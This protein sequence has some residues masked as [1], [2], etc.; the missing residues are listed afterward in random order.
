[1]R[2]KSPSGQVSL[3]NAASH[4]RPSMAL[5]LR[6]SR[7][8]GRRTRRRTTAPAAAL[9]GQPRQAR[10]CPKARS[11]LRIGQSSLAHAR[12]PAG[13]A[14]TTVADR[15]GVGGVGKDFHWVMTPQCRQCPGPPVEVAPG[16]V[17]LQTTSPHSTITRC[18]ANT[19]VVNHCRAASGL[20]PQCH[21]RHPHQRV[22]RHRQDPGGAAKP[23]GQRYQPKGELGTHT[24][25]TNKEAGPRQESQLRH[26][27]PVGCGERDVQVLLHNITRT[28]A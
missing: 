21:P 25:L 16:A 22:D 28:R 6:T 19:V 12:R 10:C 1:M 27:R 7:G 13:D 17:D 2:P 8:G 5:S 9:V 24:L 4:S 20:P 26:A 14:A 18:H 15:R 23:D 3:S 11:R